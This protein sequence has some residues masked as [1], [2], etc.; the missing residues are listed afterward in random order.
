[1]VSFSACVCKP[2]KH[3]NGFVVMT[4]PLKELAERVEKASRPDRALDALIASRL[5]IPPD[6][7]PDWLVNWFGH[8]A[9]MS[10]ADNIGRVAAIHDNGREGVNWEAA[11][12][13]GSID[14]A[15]TLVPEG[16]VW[17]L[18]FA[19]MATIMKPGPNGVLDGRIVGQWPHDQS[20]A[21]QTTTPALALCAAA[22]RAL[23]A[24]GDRA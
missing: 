22:L 23:A 21:E 14:K 20:E 6:G 3:K 17:A 4:S 15:L 24:Q 1:V 19:S 16:C 2:E 12:Y 5:R 13:T 11:P 9:P 10:G 18:N 7:A 8:Y